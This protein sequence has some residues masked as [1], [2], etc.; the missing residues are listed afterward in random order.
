MNK[1]Y[2]GNLAWGATEEDLETEFGRFGTVTETKIVRDR[3]TGRSKGFAFVTF[4]SDSQASAA[5]DGMFG[6]DMLG[7]PL[8]T[9][10]AEDRPRQ[11]RQDRGGYRQNN[12][13]NYER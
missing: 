2:V 12:R 6:K 11:P 13:H 4:E 10:I 3:D 1:V 7:R 9:S 8:K 5:V